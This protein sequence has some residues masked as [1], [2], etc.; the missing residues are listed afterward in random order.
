MSGFTVSINFS[1]CFSDI[2]EFNDLE[3]EVKDMVYEDWCERYGEDANINSDF[4][5]AFKKVLKGQCK[6]DIYTIL[7]SILKER[8]FLIIFQAKCRYEEQQRLKE[9]E[10]REQEE[11]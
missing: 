10:E 9:E 1:A 5:M 2:E 8:L 3:E 7:K 4:E 6:D 11:D